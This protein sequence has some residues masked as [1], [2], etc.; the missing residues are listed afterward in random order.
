MR[1][2]KIIVSILIL[3]LPIII[4]IV[5]AFDEYF[6]STLFWGIYI[7]HFSLTVI[8]SYRT[9]SSL[10]LKFS[11]I[12]A[13]MF[14]DDFFKKIEAIVEVEH[15]A[16]IMIPSTNFSPFYGGDKFIKRCLFSVYP[17]LEKIL[18]F[19]MIRPVGVG[20]EG[21][22]FTENH[23]KF[24]DF[25]ELQRKDS[26]SW[27]MNPTDIKLI[28][29]FKSGLAIP[30]KDPHREHGLIGVL[31]IY[32]SIELKSTS[33]QSPIFQESLIKIAKLISTVIKGMK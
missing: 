3:N 9:E 33:F 10:N 1:N 5:I 2:F 11:R 22:A 23:V 20:I 18:K 26:H 19:K 31:V 30:L 15:I 21:T 7:L 13:E 6:K 4:P 12:Q 32:S 17:D 27:G 28:D 29:K 24:A 14:L 16:F 25:D 8:R